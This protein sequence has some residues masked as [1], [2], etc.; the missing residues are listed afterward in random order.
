MRITLV[1]LTLAACGPPPMAAPDAGP[2]VA[3]AD[4]SCGAVTRPIEV[5]NLG[6][7]PDLLVVL[8]RSGSMTTEIPNPPPSFPPGG[9]TSRWEIMRGALNNLTNNYEDNIR[10]GLLEFPTDNNCSVGSTAVRVPVDIHNADAF[11]NYFGGRTPGGNTPAQAGLAAALTHYQS[12]P[13]NPVGRYVLFATDGEPNC[14]GGDA[15]AGTVAA[16]T[17]LA[18]AGVNTFVL[19]FGNGFTNDAV[20]EDAAIAG[21][22]PRPTEPH[23]YAA[24]SASALTSAFATI[25][26]G[27]AVASCSYSLESP[28]PVPEDV[29]V[30]LGGEVVPRSPSHTNGWDYYP[31]AMTITFFGEYCDDITDLIVTEVSFVYGC[32]GPVVP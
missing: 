28:P 13:V 32:P 24:D 15:A 6:D 21:L 1:V 8:D 7:P 27:I 4:T 19:G 12:I 16:V 18:E 22:V 26:G 5:E 9:T 23:Y 20:L 3:D 25:A 30:S 29:T 14:S 10:F 31:D 11:A 2:V 17:A